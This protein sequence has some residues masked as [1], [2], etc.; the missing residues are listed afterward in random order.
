MTDPITDPMPEPTQY[1]KALMLRAMQELPHPV[2]IEAEANLEVEI[3]KAVL[4]ARYLKKD[5]AYLARLHKLP[6]DEIEAIAKKLAKQQGIDLAHREYAGMLAQVRAI[7]K[8]EDPGYRTWQMQEL[9][10]QYRRSVRDLLECYHKAIAG[11]EPLT[12]LTLDQL[13]AEAAKQLDWVVRGWI[14]EATTILLHAHG[15]TGKS[16]FAYN[17]LAAVAT[18]NPWNGYPVKQGRVLALQLEEPSHVTA[19]RLETLGVEGAPITIEKNWSAE[20]MG[21]LEAYLRAQKEAGDPVVF[22]LVDSVTAM[23]RNSAVQEK[24]SAYAAPVRELTAIADRYGTAI[25]I[26]HHSSKEGSSRG[27]TD[28][29]DG[30]NEVWALSATDER[31][32]DRLLRVLKMRAGREP[33][34]YKFD[35]DSDSYEFHYKGREGEAEG[36]AVTNETRIL[37]WLSDDSRRGRPHEPA[38]VAQ[39]LGIPRE[40]A[41][42][43][44]G[45]LYSKKQLSRKRRSGRGGGFAY[46]APALPQ[47]SPAPNLGTWETKKEVSQVPD[48]FSN[49]IP[50][51]N[52]DEPGNLGSK[53]QKILEIERERERGEK[54]NFPKNVS[55]VPRFAQNPCPDSVSNLGENLGDPSSE[56]PKFEVSQV[57]IADPPIVP[58]QKVSLFLKDRWQKGGVV[59]R[60][61]NASFY[62]NVSKKLQTRV[63]IQFKGKS[64]NCAIDELRA[65]D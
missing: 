41:R 29:H 26:I 39:Q 42:R 2:E 35:F 54:T 23:N 13:R 65:E 45:E 19:E 15:G 48:L 27:T 53:N 51:V 47:T 11:L 31:T 16:L 32:G 56:S 8:G 3:L 30:V 64:M 9:A 58:G 52:T 63:A 55:Q 60:V 36:E 20:K 21:Q 34:R 44:L 14:P 57:A 7:E 62:S 18:G 61:E 46:L 40:S 4:N 38:E 1:D 6:F 49:E 5:L 50:A 59:K 28:I 24:D 10:R 12:P 33:G 25:L 43:V 37:L 22:M 17:L